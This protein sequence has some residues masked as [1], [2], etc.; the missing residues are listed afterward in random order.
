MDK[1]ENLCIFGKRLRTLR[2]KAKLTQAKPAE[3]IDVPIIFIGIVEGGE[4]NTKYENV[5]KTTASAHSHNPRKNRLKPSL[6][7][8]KNELD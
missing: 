5:Y 4:R 1:E 2:K 6:S 7:Q 8:N 3:K